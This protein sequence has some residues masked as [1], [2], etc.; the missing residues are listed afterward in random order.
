MC[1]VPPQ[2]TG[3][4]WLKHLKIGI[5]EIPDVSDKVTMIAKVMNSNLYLMGA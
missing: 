3:E 2:L 4:R 1:F 5:N